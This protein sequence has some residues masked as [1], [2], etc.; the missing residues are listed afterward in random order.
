MGDPSVAKWRAAGKT[1]LWRYL[2][3]EKNYPG[4][5]LT[6]DSPSCAALDRLFGLMA[7][8][9]YSAQARISIIPP[10]E[11][12]LRVPNNQGGRARWQS[13]DSLELKFDPD[14][15]DDQLWSVEV[16]KNML[17]ISMGRAKLHEHK[18]GIADISKGTGDYSIGPD[19]DA[20]YRAQCLWFWWH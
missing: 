6:A 11:A 7:T 20:A 15:P 2:D 16:D 14:Q 10:T 5:H 17:S 18:A 8:A 1:Y 19:N 3:N 12:Q 9:K 13:V 4:W